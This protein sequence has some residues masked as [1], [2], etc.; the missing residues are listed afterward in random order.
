MDV[1]IS[2]DDIDRAHIL[3]DDIDRAHRVG[4]RNT[5]S[6]DAEDWNEHSIGGTSFKS[7]EIIVKFTNS[8]AA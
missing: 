5:D 6:S 4:R 1:T 8:A 3:G 2:G 7:R